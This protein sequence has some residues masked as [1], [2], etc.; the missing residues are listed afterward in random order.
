MK[1]FTF[2]KVDSAEW[3]DFILECSCDYYEHMTHPSDGWDKANRTTKGG[4]RNSVGVC[5]KNKCCISFLSLMVHASWPNLFI[6]GYS[7]II[8]RVFK[9]FV[10]ILYNEKAMHRLQLFFQLLKYTSAK[11][12]V[13]WKYITSINLYTD[14]WFSGISVN[15]LAWHL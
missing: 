13:S 5:K 1:S 15:L 6:M 12:P 14:Q 3:N 10:E 4:S 11:P 8:E 7:V 2:Y 9:T